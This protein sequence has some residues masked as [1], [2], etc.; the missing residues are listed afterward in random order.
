M[1]SFFFFFSHIPIDFQ[2]YN[3]ISRKL[4]QS[5]IPKELIIEIFPYI[6]I[7]TRYPFLNSI[8]NLFLVRFSKTS[9][10]LF[11]SSSSV[12]HA[13]SLN[14]PPQRFHQRDQAPIP[15]L[16]SSNIIQHVTH[17]SVNLSSDLRAPVLHD[18]SFHA[19]PFPNSRLNRRL[20]SVCQFVNNHL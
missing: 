6:N 13:S 12:N 9:K 16:S 2:I 4:T 10:I 7:D 19:D 3:L 18:S 1:T 8:S 14:G 20:S 17:R 11:D 15:T 5:K